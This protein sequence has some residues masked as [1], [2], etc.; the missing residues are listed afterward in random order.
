[1]FQKLLDKFSY[2]SYFYKTLKYRIFVTITLGI[3]VG[4]LDGLGLAMFI[5]LLKV[6]T[7]SGTNSENS[8]S[9][10]GLLV[11]FNYL[12]I[13]VTLVSILL[14]MMFFFI[15]KSLFAFIE[16]YLR[17]IYQQ[18]FIKK[19]RNE[20]AQLLSTLSY[21]AFVSEDIGR[22]QNVFTTEVERVN[23]ASKFYF[24]AMQAFILVL[25]Y[26]SM[27]YLTN[28]EFAILISIG[29][30][31]INFLFKNLYS[32]TKSYSKALSSQNSEFQGSL[33]QLLQYF[34]YLRASGLIF[35]F[36]ERI[37]REVDKIESTNKKIGFLTSITNSLREPLVICVVIIVIY[38]QLSIFKESFSVIILSLILF[39][40]A[41]SSLM[42]MQ[43]N[44]NVFMSVSGS[45]ANTEEFT[46]QLR[47]K[48]FEYNGTNSFSFDNQLELK[49][50][51]LVI[52]DKIIIDDLTLTIKKNETIAFVGV[53]GSGK[54]TLVNI[55]SGIIRPTNGNIFLDNQNF[56]DIN[57]IDWQK[58]LGYI[59]QEPVIFTDSIF[60]NI[61]FWSEP[62]HVNLKRF[63]DAIEMASLKEFI[64]SLSDKEN[65]VLG[66]NGINLSGGQRQRI[67][68]AR[69]LFKKTAIILMD[70]ATSALDSETEEEIKASTESLYGKSTLI[71][72]AH[73]LS[74]IKHADRIVLLDK[75]KIISIGSF[76][77]LIVKSEVFNK[78]VQLQ[79]F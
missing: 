49:Q 59:T 12:N 66:N 23:L 43:N 1:M 24:M 36:T 30:I 13:P 21:N 61:T 55:I 67:S 68:I 53:S 46:N 42:S 48:G 33:M 11:I 32:K 16:S 75:G 5:P 74:T 72:I 65:T 31:L 28:P 62:T 70:E 38:I 41:L 56:D 52:R 51:S 19:I 17:V 22:I 40:R 20:N 4:I 45:L 57:M 47:Q 9:S 69:E 78:M 27:A 8:K 2:F 50:V 71:I 37:N 76:K 29:G 26:L 25:V 44:L 60:N 79:E 39:Y 54:T 64:N 35:A 63:S 58:G 73:R 3:I 6:A 34:K 77:E 15:F 7:E 10:E 18:F 14:I